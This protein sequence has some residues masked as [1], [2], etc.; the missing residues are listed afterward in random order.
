MIEITEVPDL[1]SDGATDLADIEL[2]LKSRNNVLTL[3]DGDGDFRSDECIGFLEEADIVVTNPP[4]SLFREY[5]AQLIEYRK[6]FLILGNNN[7]ITYKEVFPLIKNN[8][9][10]LGYNSNKTIEF[11]LSDEYK[12]W[13]RKDSKGVKFGKVPAISWFTNLDINKRHEKMILYKRYSPNEYPRFD[14]Y[15][16]INVDKVADIPKDYSEKMGVPITFL[17]NYNPEQF[18]I[19]DGIGRYSVLDN[20]RTK[21]AGKYLSMINGKA[22]YF[23]YIIK[24]LNPEKGENHE[25]RTS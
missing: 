15:D 25:N 3:L 1:N 9:L 11:R 17:N 4:F 16:A 8:A 13:D 18:K 24:N 2:L 7:A 10:W 20:E 22:K 21:K 6:K 5:L 23:R 14:N 19:I 12:K